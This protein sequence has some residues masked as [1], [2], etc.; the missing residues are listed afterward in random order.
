MLNRFISKNSSIEST[1][2]FNCPKVLALYLTLGAMFCILVVVDNLIFQKF[3]SI[4]LGY[5]WFS[6]SRGF[7]VVSWCVFISTGFDNGSADR[8]FWS[9]LCT[10]CCKCLC[11]LFIIGYAL[12]IMG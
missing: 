9:S 11:F 4:N 8:D 2:D 6:R 1:V 10:I 7:R 3:I 5:W 12:V